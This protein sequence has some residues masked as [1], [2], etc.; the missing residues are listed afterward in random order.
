MHEEISKRSPLHT[1]TLVMSVPDMN[2]PGPWQKL[3][4]Q[5]LQLMDYLESVTNKPQWTFG[6]GTVLMLRIN[7][8][9]SKDIDLFVPDPQYL[10]HVNP[11]LSDAAEAI[12]G[13]YLEGAL[14]VKLILEG[15]EI[16][17]VVGPPLTDAGYDFVEFEG[18]Q[19]RVETSAEIIAKKM[20]HR[21]DQANARDLYDLCAVAHAEPDA[22]EQARPFFDKHGKTFI[23]RLES[24]REIAKEEFQAIMAIGVAPDFD[25]SLRF[26]RSILTSRDYRR[27]KITRPGR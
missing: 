21:G 5:A 4:P 11:R 3:F 7:H 24:N 25:A 8:R 19:L 13:A 18:R 1:A 26:A 10:G 23:E 6:G 20:W 12:S 27:S 15:G 22:I 2:R 14:Y 17:V 9:Q 16:D